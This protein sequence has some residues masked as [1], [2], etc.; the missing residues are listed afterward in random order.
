MVLITCLDPR[1]PNQMCRGIASL[2]HGSGKKERIAVFAKDAKAQEARDAGADIVG[3]QDLADS[4]LAGK[5]DFTRCIA[6]PDM[7]AVVGKVARVLGPKGLMPNPKMGSVT[8]NIKEAIKRAQLGSVEFKC[9]KN[10]VLMAAVGKASFPLQ[11][12]REN[13]DCFF[14]AV[15]KAKPDGAK[16]VFIRGVYLSSS[17]GKGIKVK[18]EN[19]LMK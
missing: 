18:L 10:G 16:G 2:P 19:G 8:M 4:I 13:I 9:E 12:I 3:G 6:T 5:L 11:H 17:Q 14:N 15:Q 1:K 7:M